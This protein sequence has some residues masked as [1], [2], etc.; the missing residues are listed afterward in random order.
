VLVTDGPYCPA[1]QHP[2]RQK[3]PEQVRFYGST[4]WKKIRKGVRD[5]QPICAICGK[6]WSKIVDHKDGNWENND[7]SNLQGL[8]VECNATKTAKEHRRKVG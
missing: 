3:S 8:C 1:H 4:R 5:R 6:E 2:T 7:P